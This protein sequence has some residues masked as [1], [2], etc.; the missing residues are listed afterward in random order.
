MRQNQLFLIVCIYLLA[1]TVVFAEVPTFP[2]KPDPELTPGAICLYGDS[3][4]YPEKIQYCDRN[5][6]T[7]DK[8]LVI[9]RYTRKYRF[10]VNDLN[11]NQ[12]KIDHYIPLC[13]GGSNEFSNLWPQHSSIYR[14]TDLLEE[15]LCEA[16]ANG[17]ISQ[18]QAIE[19]MKQGKND[20]SSVLGLRKEL[21]E[22]K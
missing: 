18:K 9:N 15:E 11:R 12:F 22:L 6:D 13:M 20:L 16:M 1:A 7:R 8:W 3:L 14:I 5:V 10:T 21:K 19:K 2:T 4:R 17:K